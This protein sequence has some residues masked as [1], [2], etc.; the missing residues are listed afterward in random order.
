MAFFGS[1]TGLSRTNLLPTPAARSTQPLTVCMA[2][3]KGRLQLK[4]P[5]GQAR[6]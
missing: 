5:D 3:K 1:V 6:G 4:A 2:K